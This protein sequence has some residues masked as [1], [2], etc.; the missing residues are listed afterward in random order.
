MTLTERQEGR[1]TFKLHLWELPT[2][3]NLHKRSQAPVFSV[4]VC[5]HLSLHLV[6]N[7]ETAYKTV[8]QEKGENEQLL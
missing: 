8:G 4:C 2:C 5:L 6:Q 7:N 1:Q 3:I